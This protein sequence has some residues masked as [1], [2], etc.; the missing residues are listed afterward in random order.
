MTRRGLFATLLAPLVARFAPKRR[1]SKFIDNRLESAR[2]FTL[3]ELDA[4][5]AQAM[6][7]DDRPDLIWGTRDST[8][9]IEV[10]NPRTCYR[11]HSAD[12]GF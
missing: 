8:G 4:A 1:R 10:P 2:R 11:L 6:A 12:G 3:A 9:T 7:G 5:Y